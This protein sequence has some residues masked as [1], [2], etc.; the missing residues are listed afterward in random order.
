LCLLPFDIIEKG[1]HAKKIKVR[2]DAITTKTVIREITAIKS[3]IRYD[4]DISYP[5]HAQTGST[6]NKQRHSIEV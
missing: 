6:S 3:S 1:E 5:S 4:N 2:M